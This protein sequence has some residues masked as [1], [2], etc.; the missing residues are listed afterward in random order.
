MDSERLRPLLTARGPFASVYFEDSHDTPDAEAQLELRWRAIREQLEELGAAEAV[1]NEM[2]RAVLDA[3]PPVGRS[4]RGVVA[5]ADGV[6]LNEHLIRPPETPVVRLS[7]FP[8][9]VPII[10]HTGADV[11]IHNG[12]RQHTETVASQD[13]VQQLPSEEDARKNFRA[14]ADHLEHL[15]GQHGPE[16]VFVIGDKRSRSEFLGT[17]PSQVQ[18]LAVDL[19]VGARDGGHDADDVQEAIRTHMLKLRLAAIDDAAQRF[20]AEIGRQSGL[21]AEGLGPVCSGLRQGAVDT[22][23]IGDIGEETVVADEDLTSFAPT[24]EV[25]SEQGAAP[26]QTLRADEALP[27]FAV[28]V[29][30]ALVR[31]DERIAPADGVGAVLRYAPTLH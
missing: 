22:L 19:E 5:G 10:D 31:T 23:I 26:A 29:G 30:A 14:V 4:G 9:V 15:L 12:S 2:E 27:M 1:T 20:T 25:L 13:A 3:R 6:V 8:Y 16:A 28:S 17:L 24:A 18:S 7:K 11:T 21:A